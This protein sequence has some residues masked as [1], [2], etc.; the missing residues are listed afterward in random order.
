MGKKGFTLVEVMIALF[1]LVVV[2]MGMAG[3]VAT[4][5]KVAS[6]SKQTSVASSMIQDKME[7]LRNI[8]FA[9]LASGNDSVNAQGMTYQ[10]QWTI[11]QSGNIKTVDITVSY[12]GK[13]LQA[14]TVRGE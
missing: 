2:L 10:R 13:N 3:Y 1:V 12:N 14:A 4:I 9:V 5:M 8:P 11:S 6:Q 7:A